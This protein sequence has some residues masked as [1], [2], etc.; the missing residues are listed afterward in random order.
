MNICSISIGIIS[1]GIRSHQPEYDTGTIS[2]G[3]VNFT[4]WDLNEE[5]DKQKA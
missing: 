2:V 4:V 3:W 5:G 1:I